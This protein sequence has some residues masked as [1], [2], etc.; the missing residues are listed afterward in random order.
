MFT[1]SSDETGRS[2]A[3][4]DDHAASE[5]LLL[6]SANNNQT[7]GQSRHVLF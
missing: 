4:F 7:S 5:T 2:G 3:T 1:L 6:L